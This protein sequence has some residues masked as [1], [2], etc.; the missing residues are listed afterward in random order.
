MNLTWNKALGAGAGGVVFGTL[1]PWVL[2]LLHFMQPVA[3]AV[4]PGGGVMIGVLTFIVTW[5]APKNA[6]PKTPTS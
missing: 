4:I 1:V 6:G 5:L 3:A 2:E